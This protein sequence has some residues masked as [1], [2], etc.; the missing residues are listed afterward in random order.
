M[1]PDIGKVLERTPALNLPNWYVGA[2]CISQ[3]YWNKIH[4]YKFTD[5]ISDIDL[6]Y[7]DQQDISYEMEAQYIESAR[8]L[9]ADISIKIDLKNQAR[10]HLWYSSKFGHSIEQYTS[11]EEAISSWPTTATTVAITKMGSDY[12]VYAAYGLADLF[13]LVVRPNKV[14]VTEEV[15]YAKAKRWKS[16]WPKLKIIPW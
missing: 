13:D 3:T 8:H 5:H 1:N 4:G 9:F 12:K 10:V 16:H 15:Y 11:V 14:Q 6:V 2:G 7:Y